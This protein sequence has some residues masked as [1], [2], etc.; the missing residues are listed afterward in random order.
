MP[1]RF[2]KERQT[3]CG[4]VAIAAIFLRVMKRPRS[5]PP[6]TIRRRILSYW[7]KIGNLVKSSNREIIN[8]STK[9]KGEKNG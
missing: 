3:R 9:P 5:A 6:A 7:G 8:Y 2:F 1:D 4:A